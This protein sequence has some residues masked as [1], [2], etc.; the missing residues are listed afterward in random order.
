MVSIFG[1]RIH[2][3]DNS[4]PSIVLSMTCGEMMKALS[5]TREEISG[6]DFRFH[7]EITTDLALF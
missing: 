1:T 2:L 3:T 7:A 4:T 6:V 5:S